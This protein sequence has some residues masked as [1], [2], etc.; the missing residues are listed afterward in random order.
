MPSD[1]TPLTESQAIRLSVF[2]RLARLALIGS[3]ILLVVGGFLYLGG[4]FSPHELTPARFVNGFEKVFGIQ[5]GFRRNHAK[6][7]CASGFFESNGQGKRLSK[8]AVFRTGRVPII[9][10]FS[11]GGGNPYAGDAPDT[12]RGLGLLFRLPDR[13]EWRTAMINRPV[14]PFNTPQAYCFETRPQH[15]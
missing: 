6:G 14:F 11:L 12:I 4:W 10:R 8:A 9:G 5:S 2:S 13:E 7:V 3:V 1:A 15:A